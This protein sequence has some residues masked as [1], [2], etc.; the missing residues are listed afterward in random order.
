MH[1]FGDETDALIAPQTRGADGGADGTYEHA[2]PVS[3]TPPLSTH[4]KCWPESYTTKL[5]QLLV[6]VLQLLS[7][8][9]STPL[10]TGRT[11]DSGEGCAGGTGGGF[12]GAG[13][14]GGGVEGE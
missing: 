5:S 12:V 13:A 14:I 1:P 8:S 4:E 10:Q 2:S 3:H 9:I 6:C 7:A 11:G